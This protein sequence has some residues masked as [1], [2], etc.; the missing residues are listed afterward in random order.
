MNYLDSISLVRTL[1]CLADGEKIIVTGKPSRILDDVL[2]LVATLPGPIA[3]NPEQCMLT[4]RRE[5]GFLALQSEEVHITQ[6]KDI[7]EGLELLT[8]LTESINAV[9]EH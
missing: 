2:P 1:P 6:A 4:L 9:W 7:S 3:F 8:A 5:P